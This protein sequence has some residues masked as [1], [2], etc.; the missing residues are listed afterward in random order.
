MRVKKDGGQR[1]NCTMCYTNSMMLSSWPV[2]PLLSWKPILISIYIRGLGWWEVLYLVHQ[3]YYYRKSCFPFDS[4]PT[5][6]GE[7][8]FCGGGAVSAYVS[9]DE[10][11]SIRPA[12]PTAAN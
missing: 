5:G 8:I 7:L 4:D 6:G 3:F 9:L 10:D 11:C 2:F 1:Y 12:T